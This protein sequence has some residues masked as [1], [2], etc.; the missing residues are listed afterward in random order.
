MLDLLYNKRLIYVIY[1]IVEEP[2]QSNSEVP[3]F[4]GNLEK[5]NYFSC[6]DGEFISLIGVCNGVVDCFNGEDE[7]NCDESQ[8]TG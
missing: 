4:F 7:L 3:S 8:E 6:G 2:E 1:F 5:T